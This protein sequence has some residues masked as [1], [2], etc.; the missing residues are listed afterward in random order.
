MKGVIV[1]VDLSTEPYLLLVQINTL[2]STSMCHVHAHTC[3]ERSYMQPDLDTSQSCMLGGHRFKE[4]LLR[5]KACK[6]KGKCHAK[7]LSAHSLSVHWFVCK[8]PK[9]QA[10][11]LPVTLDLDL[12][13]GQNWRKL[14]SRSRLDCQALCTYAV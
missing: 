8:A 11:Q 6:S 14:R 13:L 4:G 2:V 3:C 10:A 12:N 5:K 1:S 7:N 9:A